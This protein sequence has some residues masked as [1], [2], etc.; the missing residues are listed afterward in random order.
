MSSWI[1]KKINDSETRQ[2]RL[3]EALANTYFIF[4]PADNLQD[5]STVVDPSAVSA[6]PV[7]GVARRGNRQDRA[8]QRLCRLGAPGEGGRRH[9]QGCGQSAEE[10]Q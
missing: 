2:V 6:Q 7:G 3:D 1:L 10:T 4:Y 5:E 8:S 9:Q